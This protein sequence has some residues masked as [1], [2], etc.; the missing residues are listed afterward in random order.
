ML[1]DN[2]GAHVFYHSQKVDLIWND[3]KER[4]GTS[5]FEQMLVNLDSLFP[6]GM[7]LSSLEEP[8]DQQ[9]VDKIIKQLPLHKS[10]GPDGFNNEFLKKC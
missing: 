3:F 5:N 9:E 8:F 6:L 1:A 4:L 2:S 7:D 10:L